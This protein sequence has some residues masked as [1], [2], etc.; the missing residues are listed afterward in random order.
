MNRLL[1]C[2]LLVLVGL[3]VWFS[4]HLAGSRI[5]QVDEC[6]E[7]Y[8]AQML[9]TG[10][11]KVHPQGIGLLQFPLSWL[12]RNATR[13]EEIFTAA[14][15]VM[16]EI[17]WL[18]I[19]LLALATGESL[20]STR[21]LVALLGAATLAPMWDYGFEIRHDNLL[22]TGLLLTW[23]LVRVRPTGWQSYFAAG[24]LA[25]A[26]QFA[27]HKAFAYLIPLTL[28]ILVFPPPGHK[29]PRWKLVSSWAGGALAAFAALRLVYALCGVG[30]LSEASKSGMDFVSKVSVS[31]SRFWPWRTLSRLLGQTPLLLSLVGAALLAVVVEVRRR[32]RAA[33]SWDGCL[34]ETLLFLGALGML[35]VNPTPYPYNLLHLVPFAFLLA[36]RHGARLWAE[37]ALR[38]ALSTLAVMVLVF[39]HLVTFGLVTRRHLEWTNT[40]QV[41]LMGAA[42]KLTEPAKDPVF[43][44]VGLVPTRP[45]I[46]PASFLHSLSVRSL[47][48]KEGMNVADM[49]AARPAAVIM[50]N[51][52]TDW[53]TERDHEFIRAHYVPLADDFWVLGRMLP[54]GGGSFEII[55][56][57]RYQITTKEASCVLGTVDTNPF[58]LVIPPMKT[59]CVGTLDGGALT[60]K[61]VELTVGTHRVETASDCEP[62]VVW[63]GPRLERQRPIGDRNHLQLFVNWY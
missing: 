6:T 27:A 26:M 2:V 47:L 33:L 32:G 11:A 30:E 55:H 54:S 61:A 40:R 42:E 48:D 4:L 13:A 56:P 51:Y 59:N 62:A 5:F 29:S 35:F 18:N 46:H 41:G 9:A 14:R 3:L 21:G 38:P 43:D 25:V 17:F 39:G 19:V 28:A 8:T 20:R 16:V 58:G 49:L 45:V 53:L 63:V 24:V 10:Q 44:G 36:Y 23:G 37:I 22:L 34:P 7:V 52:R 50:P 60:G 12:V 57:G 31:D 15:F 1:A